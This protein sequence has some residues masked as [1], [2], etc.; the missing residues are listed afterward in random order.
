[1]W[2]RDNW[3]WACI[4]TEYFYKQPVRF[5]FVRS[6]VVACTILTDCGFSSECKS[7]QQAQQQGCG[8]VDKMAVKMPQ[9]TFLSYKR[10][11]I[12]KTARVTGA[13]AQYCIVVC[14]WSS[15]TIMIKNEPQKS[16]LR[17]WQPVWA[18][19]IPLD[20]SEE[21]QKDW[22]RRKDSKTGIAGVDT[23]QT[24]K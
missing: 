7:L 5:C 17:H 2:F 21:N 15:R 8:E 6:F 18:G 9:A 22:Q 16:S 4:C 10:R 12:K 20:F 23:I 11:R 14:W 19:G 13:T 1:M 24:M 3:C